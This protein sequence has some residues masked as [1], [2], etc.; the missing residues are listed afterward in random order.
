M[1]TNWPTST[2]LPSAAA[3]A[4]NAEPGGAKIATEVP[5]EVAKAD[6]ATIAVQASSTTPAATTPSMVRRSILAPSV[7]IE[8][9]NACALGLEVADDLRQPPDL[10]LESG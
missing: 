2:N 4:A 9:L 7:V 5:G 8:M 6:A 1:T 3:T 10:H